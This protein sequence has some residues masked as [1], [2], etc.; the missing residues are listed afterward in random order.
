MK[1]LSIICKITI[2]FVFT[3]GAGCKKA[4]E[5]VKVNLLEQFYELNVLNKD[6]IVSYANNGNEDITAQFEGYKFRLVKN[7]FYDGP[8]TATK[9]G[10]TYTGTWGFTQDYGKL[11][12]SMPTNDE[13]K[14]GF[15]NRDWR[16]IEK[17]PIKL[18]LNPW[19]RTEQDLT[20]LHISRL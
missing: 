19:F 14:F 4:K 20:E 5:E 13:P 3:F 7:T 10:V 9:N 12:I 6:F 18:K 8:L 15:L 1:S 11:T 2:F 17:T 16:F